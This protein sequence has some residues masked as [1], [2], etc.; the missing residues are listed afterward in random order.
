[1]KILTIRLKN[2]A[3]IEG[4]FE[5]DFQAEPLRSAGIFA[6]IPDLQEPEIYDTGCALSGA[7]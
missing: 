3:S 2:L 5:I 4:T 7:V 6:N 1:M